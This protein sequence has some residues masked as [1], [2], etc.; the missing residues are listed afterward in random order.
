MTL[1]FVYE[2]RPRLSKKLS[3]PLEEETQRARTVNT[4]KLLNKLKFSI[5]NDCRTTQNKEPINS[6]HYFLLMT[7][8]KERASV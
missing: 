3:L 2:R 8:S 1:T 6:I 5:A 7:D 4:K